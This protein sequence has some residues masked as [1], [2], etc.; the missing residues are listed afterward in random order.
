VVFV[1]RNVAAPFC[2]LFVVEEK[3]QCAGYFDASKKVA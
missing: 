2:M 1:A 3:Y